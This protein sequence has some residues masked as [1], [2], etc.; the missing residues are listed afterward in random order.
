M[1]HLVKRRDILKSSLAV[2]F[3]LTTPALAL[4][5][6][7]DMTAAILDTFGR[8]PKESDAILLKIPPISENGYS[9]PVEIEVESPMTN[10]HFVKKIALFSDRNPL[11]L[12]AVYKL[13]PRSGLAKI[14]TRVRLG[15]TQS[16]HA[17]AEMRN[18]DL[19]S[20]KAKTLVTVAACVIL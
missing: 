2:S 7:D 11:P 14:S 4:A 5:K 16:V 18:G 17:I 10:K 6:T 19:I 9:V 12:L 3:S 1:K 15:G 13:T 20:A 8:L